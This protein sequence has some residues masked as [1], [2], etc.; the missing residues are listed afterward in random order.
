M[1]YDDSLPEDLDAACSAAL[2]ADVACDPLVP[3]LRHDFYYPPATL[4]RMCTDGCASALQSW[5][6]S[7][8]SACG[9]DIVIP[10]EDDLDASPIV[11][12][13]SRRYTYGFTCLKENDAF[14]GPVAALAAF[15]TNPGVSAFNY[16]N[17]L[18]EGAVKPA[19]CDPCL[20]ARL[21]LRSG[22]PYF[23]GPVVASESIYQTLTSSCG[24]TGKPA[25]TSTI[26]YFTSEPQPTESVCDGTMYQIQG[27]DDC[28]SISKAQ[29]LMAWNPVIN[30]VCSNLNMMNGTTLCIEPPGPKLPP[31]QTTNVPPVTPTS[32]APIP[33]NTAIGSDKPCG[34]WYEVEAGDYCN[35]VTLK[36]AISLDDFMFLNTGINA[37]CTNLFTQES[38]CVQA[39]GDINN[40]PGRPGYA[41]VTIDPNESFTGVPF[42]MLPNATMT[43]DPR[44]TQLPLATGVR[45][46]CVFYFKGDDYQYSSDVFG[47]WNSNCEI[48]ASNYNVDFDS[49]IAWNSLTT[50]VTDPAC[51]FQVGLRYCGSWDLPPTQTTT[52]EEPEPT[53]TGPQP[54]APTHEGQ[55]EDCDGWHVVVSSDSC[56]SVADNAGISLATFFEWNPAVSADCTENFWLGQAYCTHREGQG[57]ST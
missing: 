38:Y 48:A 54:P 29:S 2:M 50:N 20:A 14:C 13:A 51:V 17:V 55:P 49:F 33:S 45:D 40:Y 52:T 19:D 18:P 1:L 31:D 22:S 10:A 44:P 35:L 6:S 46:D 39:V 34:R 28:Y 23:D 24:I 5:E 11:I 56:Q 12:P 15:F 21:R 43:L 53:E 47:Y 32:A 9:N 27:G 3:A 37:N 4:T 8:R 7:V 26:D 36:F 16:I 57:I 42:I 41:S 25:T 30:P